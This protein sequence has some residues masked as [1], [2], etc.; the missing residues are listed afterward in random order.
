MSILD[1]FGQPIRSA[2]SHRWRDALAK[3]DAAQTTDDNMRHWAQADGLSADA[4]NSPEVRRTL[5]NRARYEVANN[6]YA[7]SM[8]ET[9]ATAVIGTGP[10]LRLITGDKATD[11]RVRHRWKRWG[12][13]AELPSKL[14]T[15]RKAKCRDGEG[16]ALFVQNPRLADEVK[17]ALRPIDTEQVATPTLT[18]L[19]KNAVDGIRFDEVGNPREYDILREHPG[20]ALLGG[21]GHFGQADA[22]DARH[23]LHLFHANR[24]GQHRG[25]PELTPALPL[26]G[27]LRRYVLAVLAA[28]ETAADFAAVIQTPQPVDSDDGLGEASQAPETM[29]VFEL[30]QRMVTVLPDGYQ[31]GQLKAEQPAFHF[32]REL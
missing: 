26:F 10:R 24:P 25:I 28:A 14:I 31:L 29:D 23:V 3:Y 18:G 5:R 21:R 9:L 1:E 6:C 4:A 11:E 15:L 20:S 32:F 17:L 22:V 13:A 19:G 12:M 16:V 30:A 7:K 27:Q 8:V 2:R